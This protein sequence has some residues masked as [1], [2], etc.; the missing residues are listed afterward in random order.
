MKS[1]YIISRLRKWWS[2]LWA[3]CKMPVSSPLTSTLTLRPR[4]PP[5]QWVTGAVP[6]GVKWPRRE[7]NHSPPSSTEVKNGW[8]VG[9]LVGW[10]IPVAPTWSIGHPWNASFHFSFLILRQ[11]VRL[12][13]RVIRPSQG[14]YLAQTRSKHR[15]TSMPRVG[16]EPRI[17]V[18]ERAKT[19]HTLDRV[20]TLISE[21]KNGGS[22][23]P[24]LHVFM[25]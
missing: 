4:Q 1:I 16:F 18:L 20:A 14:R 7:A 13:G 23:S 21:V 9:W 3:S 19:F 8:L 25:A 24:L 2:L 17:P 15:Q 10:F 12:L 11:S 6:Q 5:I 22:V